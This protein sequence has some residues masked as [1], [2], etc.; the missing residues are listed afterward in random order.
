MLKVWIV[1]TPLLFFVMGVGFSLLVMMLLYLAVLGTGAQ[2][3]T[4]DRDIRRSNSSN[5]YKGVRQ[6]YIIKY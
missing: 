4:A 2:S 3:V 5:G 1:G 6:Q